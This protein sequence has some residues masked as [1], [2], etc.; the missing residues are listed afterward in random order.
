M[1]LVAN[2][3][4]YNTR[5]FSPLASKVMS[6]FIFFCL[7]PRYVYAESTAQDLFDAF[8]MLFKEVT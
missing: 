8:G 7:E 2:M 4:K 6:L 1:K 3:R 5:P